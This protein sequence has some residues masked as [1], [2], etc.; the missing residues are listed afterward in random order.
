MVDDIKLVYYYF[1]IKFLKYQFPS[2]DI[3]LY[4]YKE[5]LKIKLLKTT[6]HF[7]DFFLYKYFVMVRDGHTKNSYVYTLVDES[8]ATS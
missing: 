8:N 4:C 5:E 7:W 2:F 1:S 3:S 6:S